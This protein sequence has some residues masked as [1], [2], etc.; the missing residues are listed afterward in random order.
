MAEPNKTPTAAGL[1]ALLNTWFPCNSRVTFRLS[2]SI[3]SRHTGS[4][5]AMRFRDS[6]QD[7]MP[8][9]TFFPKE[10]RAKILKL[11]RTMLASGKTVTGVN[12]ETMLTPDT[13]WT[14][15][16]GALWGV[17][18]WKEFRAAPAGTG[19]LLVSMFAFYGLWLAILIASRL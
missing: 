19:K 16:D 9:S 10:A 13:E 12:P 4:G 15:I 7:A 1:N 17:F 18:V 11:Y 3:S 14:R 5:E 2:R 6:M 8:A